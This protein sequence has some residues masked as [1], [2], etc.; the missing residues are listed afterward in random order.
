MA[1][2]SST[3]R[4]GADPLCPIVSCFPMYPITQVNRRVFGLLVWHE[5]LLYPA[6]RPSQAALL[7]L[8]QHPGFTSRAAHHLLPGSCVDSDTSSSSNVE[9]GSEVG[10]VSDSASMCSSMLSCQEQLQGLTVRG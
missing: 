7:Q 5:K 10:G 1:F 3:C 4:H 8:A 6:G 2:G 9:E